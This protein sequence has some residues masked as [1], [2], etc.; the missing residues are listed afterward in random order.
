M[1]HENLEHLE[2][3]MDFKLFNI[4]TG[5]ILRLNAGDEVLNKI[6]ILLLKGKYSKA[7]PKKEGDFV[8]ECREWL[9][10]FLGEE[11][12]EEEEECDV[13]YDDAKN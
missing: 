12:K 13:D 2:N 6:M 7:V 4:K 11:E 5:E 3:V 1:T 8:I 10:E 9:D